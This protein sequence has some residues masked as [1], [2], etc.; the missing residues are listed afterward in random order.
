MKFRR[1]LA[2][3]VAALALAF[4]AA[5]VNASDDNASAQPPAP[6][7]IPVTQST[8]T[9]FNP[10]LPTAV[11]GGMGGL[12]LLLCL[13]GMRRG[14]KG[15]VAR[16]VAGTILL[17]AAAN[18]EKLTSEFET[19]PTE[20]LIVID[21]SESQNI[22]TRKATTKTSQ[23]ALSDALKAL[24]G[25]NVKIVTTDVGANAAKEQ[26]TYILNTIESALSDIPRERIG[27]VFVISDGQVHDKIPENYI[28]GANIPVHSLITGQEGEVD[29]TIILQEASRFGL[30][31]KK[32]DIKF[33]V[34]D[35]GAPEGSKD[36]VRVTV[37][38]DGIASQVVHSSTGEDIT[39]SVNVAHAGLNIFE[40]TAEALDN[41][42]STINNRVVAQIEGIHE[43]LSVLILSGAPNQNTRMWRN[44]LKS[45]PD[46]DPVHFMRQRYP[47]QLDD[48]PRNELAL[49]PFPMNEIFGNNLGKFDLVILDSYDNRHLLSN[50][51]LENIAKYVKE[52]GALLIT[53]GPEYAAPGSLYNSP[54]GAILPAAPDGNMTQ[55]D[56]KA[57]VNKKGQRHPVTRDLPGKNE[58]TD[59]EKSSPTWESWQRQV[60]VTD[61]KGD[62]IMDGQGQKP[63]L[64]LSKQ[65]KGR[66]A[67]LL[68]DS[69]SRWARSMNGG[70]HANLLLNTAHW[71]MKN[72]AL[73]EE[74]LSLNHSQSEIIITQQTMGDT[75]TPVT[76]YT[77]SGKEIEVKPE[78]LREGLWQ[79][80]IPAE[81]IGL[82]KAE[83]K[84]YH[85][86]IAFTN[87]GIDNS[88]EFDNT[89]S[90]TKI[91][92][93]L[94]QRT[95]G[96][97]TRIKLDSQDKA[98][99]PA[100]KA[101]SADKNLP[102]ASATDLSVRMT[103][104]K[105][106]RSIE[107]SP[108]V[109]YSLLALAFFAAMGASF[110]Q[111]S[112]RRLFKSKDKV[113]MPSPEGPSV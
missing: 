5:Q 16:A 94:S 2:S 42:T 79:S 9:T 32:Q 108:V 68:S 49:M 80:R 58:T 82:Y 8:V 107:K 110:W 46:V 84:G 18:H 83:Q 74:A 67:M 62:V 38:H 22:G 85:P 76:V 3:S 55:Q 89:A 36:K 45:D 90:T 65:E 4:S 11:L 33:R 28:P 99:L 59:T 20:T 91:L 40:I 86:R 14:V 77:P 39:I 104:V 48:T 37:H 63:L 52:G 113:K 19:L 100:L 12:C 96:Q 30:V 41:E 31:D 6:Q 102:S 35:Q 13:Y 57:F 69:A 111:Q 92:E 51:Y 87:A 50:R 73:E 54:I 26:G 64:I 53:T 27:A 29:R 34:I 109:P 44:L 103:E 60:G 56:F 10:Y 24:P 47:E 72:P 1:S 106:T 23:E 15:N 105:V 71:L 17:Y 43:K 78:P 7:D 97:T 66:V 21:N 75:S 88:R 70:P 98:V 112:E 95:G 25:V 61:I 81:E 93:P 101:I